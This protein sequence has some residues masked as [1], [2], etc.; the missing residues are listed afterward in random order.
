MLMKIVHRIA[1]VMVLVVLLAVSGFVAWESLSGQRWGNMLYILDTNRL[2]TGFAAGAALC[3]SLIYAFSGLP[4]RKR[5]RYLSYDKEGGTVSISTEA[6][7][8]YISKLAVEFPSVVKMKPEVIP[9]RRTIDIILKVRVK[10]GP[11]IHEMCELMQKRV[12]EAMSLG[13]GISDVRRVEVS[14]REIASEH[15][16]A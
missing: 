10:A 9:G 4:E 3:L 15:K 1:A 5:A 11:D 14:V 2:S 7:C 13:L 16:L 8:D 12:R 6:I